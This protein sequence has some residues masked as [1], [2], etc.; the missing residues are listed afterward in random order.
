MSSDIEA[1]YINCN[2]LEMKDKY[3]N[4][5]KKEL[6]AKIFLGT[7]LFSFI[8]MLILS[9]IPLVATAM[10]KHGSY[11]HIGFFIAIGF[12]GCCFFTSGFGFVIYS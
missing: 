5:D 11:D 2:I 3:D 8:M 9:L 6:K 10:T 4:A 1:H 12:C 7:F